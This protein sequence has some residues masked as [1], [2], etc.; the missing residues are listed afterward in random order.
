MLDSGDIEE[1]AKVERRLANPLEALEPPKWSGDSARWMKKAGWLL[2]RYESIAS[3]LIED[4]QVNPRKLVLAEAHSELHGREPDNPGS[5]V[6]EVLRNVRAVQMAW[7]IGGKEQPVTTD[8]IL[9]IHRALMGE[10]SISGRL[11]TG[12]NWISGPTP[13]DAAHVPPP[14]DLVPELLDDLI[15]YIN[16]SRGNPLV[17]MAVAHAQFEAIHPFA[18]GNGRTGR[19]IMLLMLRR[20]RLSPAYLPP[21]SAHIWSR[22]SEYYAAL[23]TAASKYPADGL[24]RSVALRPWIMMAA[25][26]VETAA[27]AAADFAN[28]IATAKGRFRDHDTHRG[29]PNSAEHLLGRLPDNP[30]LD[31]KKAARIARSST[32][33]GNRNLVRLEEAGVLEQVTDGRR[34]RIYIAPAVVEIL[35]RAAG[36]LDR[37]VGTISLSEPPPTRGSAGRI[38]LPV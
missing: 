12:Q 9:E 14:P 23:S 24:G 27:L 25:R 30:M 15:G 16:S 33:T 38:S 29:L 21:I 11:R 3:S 2:T 32:D 17:T 31:A 18:D 37:R 8:D 4:V 22:R 13:L 26:A 6:A 1:L 5:A 36:A 35:E 34:N 20:S 19:A 10:S 7:N 28:I